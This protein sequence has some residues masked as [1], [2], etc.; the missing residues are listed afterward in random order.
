MKKLLGVDID[1]FASISPDAANEGKVFFFG[2]QFSL[3]QILV[4]TNV[5]TNT[6][7]YNFADPANGVFS[8]IDN[9]L[10]LKADTSAMSSTDVLQ[11]FVDT[12]EPQQVVANQSDDLLRMLSRLVKLL[13]S[14]AI[15]DQQQRQ[16]VTIDSISANLNLQGVNVVTTVATVNNVAAQS[17]LAGMDREMY[18]N[19]AKNTYANSIRSQLSFV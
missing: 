11:V 10:R 13:E 19:V 8:F 18:I 16:R 17:T 6:I 2:R 1:G 9:V 5:T 14:N 7:I 4:I 3:E 15:V 12:P